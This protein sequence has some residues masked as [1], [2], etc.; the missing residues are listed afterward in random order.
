MPQVWDLQRPWAT[1]GARRQ[2]IESKRVGFW[3]WVFPVARPAQA[4]C[5][6]AKNRW[7][8]AGRPRRRKFLS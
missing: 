3:V 6:P 5:Q 7:D 2:R 8:L 1:G 4:A